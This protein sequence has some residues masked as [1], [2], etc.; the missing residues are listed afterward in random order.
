MVKLWERVL[1]CVVCGGGRG[2]NLLKKLAPPGGG[3]DSIM[4]T[5]GKRAR[6]WGGAKCGLTLFF[7]APKKGKVG[8]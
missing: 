3:G 8:K 1:C 2:R 7:V 4:C 6:M 5:T